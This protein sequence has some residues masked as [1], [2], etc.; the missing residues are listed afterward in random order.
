MSPPA[1]RTSWRDSWSKQRRAIR[2]IFTAVVHIRAWRYSQG[3]PWEEMSSHA[4]MLGNRNIPA[5]AK[6]HYFLPFTDCFVPSPPLFFLTITKSNPLPIQAPAL[7]PHTGWVQWQSV[8]SKLQ[9]MKCEGLPGTLTGWLPQGLAAAVW[10]NALPALQPQAQETDVEIPLTQYSKATKSRF[11]L[12]F[13]V[14]ATTDLLWERKRAADSDSGVI[15][16]PCKQ[17]TEEESRLCFVLLLFFWLTISQVKTSQVTK[18]GLWSAVNRSTVLL[19]LRQQGMDMLAG[20]HLLASRSDR[21]KTAGWV[22]SAELEFISNNSEHA[23]QPTCTVSFLPRREQMH[24]SWMQPEICTQVLKSLT[25]PLK[26]KFDKLLVTVFLKSFLM[27]SEEYLMLLQ[28]M[29]MLLF[30]S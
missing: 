4:G 29:H 26:V 21:Q 24:C 14:M 7:T 30:S 12:V 17:A 1:E 22:Q 9:E 2:E 13:Y 8:F 10:S 3:M 20:T 23:L 28:L 16:L 6:F 5:Q 27:L 11:R 18:M 19:C 25:F 15:M